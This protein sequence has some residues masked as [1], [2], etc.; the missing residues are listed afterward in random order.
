M[1]IAYGVMG[2]GRGHASRCAAVLPSLRAEHEVTVFAGGDAH[3]ALAPRFPTVK[4]PT[5]G[6]VYNGSGRHSFWKTVGGN[7]HG[8]SDLLL[9]GASLRAVEREFQSRGIE[10]VISDS[11][12]WTHRAA[13]TLGLPRISFDH[14]GIIAWCKPH[15]PPELSLVGRRDAWGYR[16][17]MGR[18]DRVLISSF[19][20]AEPAVPGLHLVGP[21]QRPEVLSA[22]PHNGNFLLAYFNKGQHQ[23]QP[24]VDRALRQL[25]QIVVVYGTPHRGAVDNL[26]F[27]APSVEGFLR[28]LSQCRA[29]IATAGNVLIGEALYLRKPILAL[30]ED[31]FEQR[32]NAWMVEQMGVGMQAQLSRLTP[33]DVDSF[34][35]N[36]DTYRRNTQEYARDGRAEAIET[37]QRF[38]HELRTPKIKIS[39]PAQTLAIDA[40]AQPKG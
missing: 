16:A 7:Y 3:A 21:L 11:E 1:R 17:L 19:Y 39:A 4:I 35:G 38:I 26:E 23:Y 28:D 36:L 2:Y 37:L 33:S 12:A 25:D 27:R 5:L 18:P 20:P 6:Y 9:R 29:V 22:E 24:D 34:L 40:S 10:L 14:V 8:M 30:P 15:F 32:L 31:A 13:H